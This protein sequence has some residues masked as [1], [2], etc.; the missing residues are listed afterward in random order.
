M[1]SQVAHAFEIPSLLNRAN[2]P[3]HKLR[4]S[5]RERFTRAAFRVSFTRSLAGLARA[6]GVRRAARQP[7]EGW[8]PVARRRV[9]SGGAPDS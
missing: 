1:L 5:S 2:A 8:L 3:A 7:Q 9:G 6:D 4:G